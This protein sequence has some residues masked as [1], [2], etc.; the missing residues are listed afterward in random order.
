MKVRVCFVLVFLIPLLSFSQE[1]KKKF[2]FIIAD[3]I[4]ADVIEKDPTPAMKKIAA[5]GGYARAHVGG[6]RAS[7]SQTPTISA[8]GYN[9]LLTGTW[10]NKHNVWDNDIKDPNYHY[11]TIF[12]FFKQQYPEK[13]IGIFSTWTDNRTKLVG[14]ALPQTGNIKFDYVAD[15]Y[16]LDTVQFPHDKQSLYIH[17]IDERVIDEAA[18]CIRDHAPDLSWIYLEY[19]D[20]IGHRY[21]TSKEQDEAVAYLDKQIERIWT[22]IEFRKKNYPEDWG[23]IITTDHG[24]DAKSGRGHGGQSDRERTTWMVSNL[25]N[26]NSYFYDDNPGI[27]DIMPTIARYFQLKIPTQRQMEID[28]LALTG[29]ISVSDFHAN[30]SNDSISLDWKTWDKQG[31]LKIWLSTSNYFKEGGMDNY[32]LITEVPI[33]RGHY[34]FSTKNNPSTFYKIVLEAPD[35]FTNRWI[36]LSIK[37]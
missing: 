4:P 1:T 23:I 15:G 9:S 17:N 5:I 11:W 13:K 35:N 37:K 7:Y 33:S 10:V 26:L 2:V 3:G 31:N 6:E 28:G 36:I 24:R 22:A 8:V 20:D 12:R 25:P 14:E 16:E 34:Q 30:Y 18:K 21:G 32:I 19:T 29:K 27:V